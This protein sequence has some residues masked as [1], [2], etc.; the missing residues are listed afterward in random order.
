M[1]LRPVSLRIESIGILALLTAAVFIAFPGIDLAVTGLFGDGQG[2]PLR[3]STF[4]NAVRDTMIGL[5]DGTMVVVIGMLVAGLVWPACR[6]LRIRVLIFAIACYALGPGL[7]VNAVF[8]SHSGRAR[9]WNVD[10]FGG[11]ATFSPVLHVADQCRS[12]CSFVSGEGSTLAT[13]ATI[14]LLLA[15]PA[16][17]RR[18]RIAAGIC[19]VAIAVG[20]SLLRVAFGAHFLSDVI[21]SWLIC[22]PVVLLLY[23]AFGLHR[24]DG[25]AAPGIVRRRRDVTGVQS[26]RQRA[27]M[28]G[29]HIEG[30]RPVDGTAPTRRR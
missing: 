3:R 9:P 18:S 7:L 24:L 23:L 29:L 22:V 27:A 19:I 17:P 12:H 16:L 6:V 26:N 25:V 28:D 30:R 2:F 4:W 21:F 10:L 14:L 20:G 11:D 5:T 8:K 13:V 1:D 15:V